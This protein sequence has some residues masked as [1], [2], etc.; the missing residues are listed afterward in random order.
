MQPLSPGASL[1]TSGNRVDA[2][3]DW[4]EAVASN[5]LLLCR[6]AGNRF[7]TESAWVKQGLT[8]GT[9]AA[10][11]SVLVANLNLY[12]NAKDLAAQMEAAME[13]R[14]VIEQA[15]GIIIDRENCSPDSAFNILT[16]LSQNQNVKLRV[17]AEMIVQQAVHGRHPR[18]S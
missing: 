18:G 14:A 4:T 6:Q 17:V 15:K 11:V 3:S 2:W 13:S 12:H 5:S 9:V 10:A 1:D 16:R 8:A 7:P